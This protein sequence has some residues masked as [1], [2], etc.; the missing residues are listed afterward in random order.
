ML[1]DQVIQRLSDW[2]KV[3][4]RKWGK[5]SL[6]ALQEKVDALKE[7][8]NQILALIGGLVARV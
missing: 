8:D 2:S 5:E 3:S 7:L 6:Q 1:L 4:D